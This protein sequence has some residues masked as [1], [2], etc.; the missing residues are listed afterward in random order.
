MASMSIQNEFSFIFTDKTG[1]DEAVFFRFY[2]P[3][4]SKAKE[5]INGDVPTLLLYAVDYSFVN[6]SLSIRKFTNLDEP[7]AGEDVWGI[8]N[9]HVTF[10]EI[11]K[12]IDTVPWD[13]VVTKME[14]LSIYEKSRKPIELI[15][16]HYVGY[17]CPAEIAL[18]RGD[19][20][21]EEIEIQ[22]G[23]DRETILALEVIRDVPTKLL[24]KEYAHELIRLLQIVGYS[25]D[26]EEVVKA[27][28]LIEEHLIPKRSKVLKPLNLKAIKAV[29][30]RLA[31]HLSRKCKEYINLRTALSRGEQLDEEL[32]KYVI[33]QAYDDREYRISR[34]PLSELNTLIFSP[35]RYVND[36][37]KV[38]FN[39][40]SLKT[41]FP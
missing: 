14:E 30:I 6:D 38:Y 3:H 22:Y 27:K 31:R 9:N 24:D 33:K 15:D 13:K 11:I 17:W 29:L 35:P 20:S 28:K 39:V 41:L 25:L 2:L 37:L 34:L 10:Q 21:P 26:K 18:F 23:P 32:Y 7:I 12:A 8:F 16:D 40:T 1:Q 19:L 5:C 4:L 36:L